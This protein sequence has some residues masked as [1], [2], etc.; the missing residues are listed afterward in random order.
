M[1]V[2]T[3]NSSFLLKNISINVSIRISVIG[4]IPV[5]MEVGFEEMVLCY[6]YLCGLFAAG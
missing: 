3:Q 2:R 5:P 1:R 4:Y 6:F